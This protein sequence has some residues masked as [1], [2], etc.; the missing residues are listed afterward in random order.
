[1][2]T[3]NYSFNYLQKMTMIGVWLIFLFLIN[4]M[5]Q[6]WMRNMYHEKKAKYMERCI[7]HEKVSAPQ[8]KTSKHE[9]KQ[10]LLIE[11]AESFYKK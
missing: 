6:I 3:R 11:S 2:V 10:R 9:H 4:S 1:M 5:I 7:I 8:D